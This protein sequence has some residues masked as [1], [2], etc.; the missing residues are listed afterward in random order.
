MQSHRFK[1]ISEIPQNE[2]TAFHRRLFKCKHVTSLPLKK[3]KQSLQ[4]GVA[5]NKAEK[6]IAVNF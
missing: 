1:N 6:K 2:S 5:D 3:G 4:T